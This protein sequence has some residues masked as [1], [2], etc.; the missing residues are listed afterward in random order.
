VEC[1]FAYIVAHGIIRS[2]QRPPVLT[3]IVFS[4]AMIPLIF[5]KKPL[6]GKS[7]IVPRSKTTTQLK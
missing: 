6:S 4:L 7:L 5:G 1:G 3:S 2:D